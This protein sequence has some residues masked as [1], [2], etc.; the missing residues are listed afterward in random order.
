MLPGQIVESDHPLQ[1][2][3]GSARCH[4]A[5]QFARSGASASDTG[6]SA[7]ARGLQQR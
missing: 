2:A 1:P 7:S 6:T 4:S 3:A 5:S